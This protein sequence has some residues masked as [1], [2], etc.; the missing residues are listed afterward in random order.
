MAYGIRVQAAERFQ[1]DVLQGAFLFWSQTVEQPG[2]CLIDLAGVKTID[3]T[4]LA[5]LAHWQRHLAQ[6]QRNLILFRPSAAVWAALDRMRLTEH[7]VITDGLTPGPRSH[8]RERVE[9]LPLAHA[10]GYSPTKPTPTS[11]YRPHRP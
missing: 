1:R 5:F 6:V 9:A 8:E 4:G 11:E 7:F 10:R 2:H 3:S